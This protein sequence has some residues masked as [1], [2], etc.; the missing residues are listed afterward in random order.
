M[1]LSGRGLF[2]LTSGHSSVRR[3]DTADASRSSPHSTVCQASQRW[4]SGEVQSKPSA[5]PGP[6]KAPPDTRQRR[7]D[8]DRRDSGSHASTSRNHK[9]RFEF[10]DS[11]KLGRSKTK[12]QLVSKPRTR[13][14]PNAWIVDPR[15]LELLDPD[16]QHRASPQVDRQA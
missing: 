12:P 11:S 7:Q 10:D 14:I 3:A 5:G 2:A 13:G 4:Y 16:Q 9:Q 15:D 8:E 1:L 6:L